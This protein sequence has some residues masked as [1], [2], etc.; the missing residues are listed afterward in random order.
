MSLAADSLLVVTACWWN[1]VLND[2]LNSNA[3]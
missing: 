3:N 1:M 2:A